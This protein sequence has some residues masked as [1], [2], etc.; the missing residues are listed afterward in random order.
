METHGYARRGKNRSPE[1]TAWANMK[2]RCGNPGFRQYADYGG[3]GIRVCDRWK[4]SFTAF[5]GDMGQRPSPDHT[6]ERIDNDVGYSPHNCRWA[7]RAEQANNKRNNVD[8]S[9]SRPVRIGGTTL[10]LAKWAKNL[11]VPWESLVKRMKRGIDP[12]DALTMRVKQS[13][14]LIEHNGQTKSVSDWARHYGLS[15]NTLN[16]R[17]YRGQSFSEAIK[18]R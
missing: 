15:V 4:R 17:L 14:K 5:L 13:R 12:V 2:A 10:P 8:T 3:R 1:Y 18:D 11:D 16:G 7:T 9:A 6:I